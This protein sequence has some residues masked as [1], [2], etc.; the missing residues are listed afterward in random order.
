MPDQERIL[1]QLSYYRRLVALL[2]FKKGFCAAINCYV[3]LLLM[4]TIIVSWPLVVTFLC[5]EGDSS[6]AIAGI[7]FVFLTGAVV[8]F[9]VLKTMLEFY[10]TA[11]VGNLAV[12]YENKTNE[13]K[14]SPEAVK[15]YENV[16][17]SKDV[18]MTSE[19]K[20]K[21]PYDISVPTRFLTA[22]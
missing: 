4:V 12:Y 9:M 18:V 22:V 20:G 3:S 15:Y 10:F 1:I 17:A 19:S 13:C 21:D 16:I 6:Y 2:S 8:W 11:S 5:L 14:L 7:S